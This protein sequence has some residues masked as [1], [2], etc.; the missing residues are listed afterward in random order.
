MDDQSYK[1]RLAGFFALS[2]QARRQVLQ[3][4]CDTL[5]PSD[6]FALDEGLSLSEAE[7]LSENVVGTFSLPFSVAA[8]FVVDNESVLVP[9][10]TEEP[11]IVA[12]ASKMAKIVAKAGG[13]HT[14]IDAPIIKGQVQLYNLV[15]IDKA[16]SI[17]LEN[18]AHLLDFLNQ[19][20]PNMV[21]RGGGVI[22]IDCRTLS[23][24]KM[25]PMLLIE[26]RVNVVDAMGANIVNRL[27]ELLG[28]KLR[29]LLGASV[30]L[31]ILSNL[32]DERLARAR[33]SLPV[34]L[35]S[36]DQGHDFGDEIAEKIMI[37]HALAEIDPYR[38]C[39]HNKGI[40]NG[41]DAVAIATGSDF[42]ALEAGAH[43]F[44]ARG[45]HY[46][47]LTDLSYDA[48]TRILH[49]NLVMPLAVGVVGGNC[50]LHRGVKV[51]HKILGPFA[52]SSQK[53]ASVMVSV[54][55]SQCL[56][57]LFALSSEGI[58]KGHMRLHHKKLAEL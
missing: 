51:A 57:A 13:F 30:C 49:A 2:P 4:R 3:A 24:P 27:M 40:M 34:Q 22:G 56:A 14:E 50:G 36:P 8:N 46:R 38:A 5:S 39:T 12:A 45:G 16:Q 17:F 21:K 18:K 48:D 26:P 55:L 20:C 42:R 15:D 53:L 10:V 44:A 7:H 58:Q 33:C 41:V 47:A 25:G 43:A 52:Q 6:I 1:S 9:F 54:G 23:S 29:L 32:C 19:S 28:E 11:S 31:R 35:L 37:G